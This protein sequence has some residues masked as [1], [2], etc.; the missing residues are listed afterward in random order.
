MPK[1][2][3]ICLKTVVAV[4]ALSPLFVSAAFA[5]P[6]D[7]GFRTG[8]PGAGCFLPGLGSTEQ[9]FFFAAGGRFGEVDSVSGTILT[10]AS[11]NPSLPAGV[12]GVATTGQL[13]LCPG[14]PNHTTTPLQ[15][16]SGLGPG[17]NMNSCAGCHAQPA[18]GGSSP[19]INN[20]QARVFN[21]DGASNRLPSFIQSDG[22]GPVRE[23]RFVKNPDGTADGGVHDLF[24]IAGRKDAPRCTNRQPDFEGALDRNNVIFRI[25]TPVFGA[26]QIE[27]T[28][29]ASLE[30]DSAK[31]AS[32]QHANGIASGV[33]NHSGNDGTITRFGWKAQNKSLLIFAGEAYNVEQGVTNENFPNERDDTPDCQF[34]AL[35][36]DVTNLVNPNFSNGKSPASDYSSDI[37]NFAGFMRLLAGPTPAPATTSTTAGL[38]AFNDVGCSLCHLPNHTTAS[39][40]FTGQSN[41]PFS[42]FSDVALHDMGEGL[43][44][45]VS[46]GGADGAQFRSAPLWGVGQRIF[47]LHDGRT[48]DLLEAIRQ[49]ASEGSEANTVIGNF[50]ALG[51]SSKQDILNFLRSL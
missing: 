32:S 35:P 45:N 39:S 11:Q 22:K 8:T 1:N 9:A 44:D 12:Q 19:P 14:T 20:P 41:K 51:D 47:F 18:V 3:G 4:I 30:S 48:K 29:D 28:S 15:S 38:E 16:G 24:V 17:F 13:T 43:A 5:D 49:H 26:G 10:D 27:N 46:Q 7:H 36:E 50:N 33:F 25:P 34:N 40:I 42:P 6:Q 23:A 2:L 21:L 37:V 31:I